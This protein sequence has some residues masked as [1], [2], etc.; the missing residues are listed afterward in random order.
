M[1][2]FNPRSREGSDPEIHSS[3]L[4]LHDFNP[5]SREGSDNK[6]TIVE[7]KNGWDFNPRSREGSDRVHVCGGCLRRISIRAPARGATDVMLADTSNT[8]IS[9]RAPARGATTPAIDGMFALV[10]QSALPR[11]ERR[12]PT[13]WQQHRQQISIRAPARGATGSTGD[14][15]RR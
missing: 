11:G 4:I 14:K 10:F 15:S 12:H 9:I 13:G 3:F 5:R 1:V 7:E 6:Y 8:Y 2:Y